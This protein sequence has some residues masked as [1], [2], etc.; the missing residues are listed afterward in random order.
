MTYFAIGHPSEDFPSRLQYF[1]FS[2]LR[3]LPLTS[4]LC[5]IIC[6]K[7][8]SDF[9]TPKK[10]NKITLNFYKIN[11]NCSISFLVDSEF[12]SDFYKNSFMICFFKREFFKNL[13]IS[14]YELR[15][16]LIFACIRK[17]DFL[18]WKINFF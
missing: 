12:R 4:H 10:R 1:A 7:C 13:I 9:A 5:S 15:N 17:G 8:F 2:I 11:T 14:L 16:G 6:L 18:S 3:A